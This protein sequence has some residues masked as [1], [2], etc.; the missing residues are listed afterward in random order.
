MLCVAVNLLDFLPG[1]VVSVTFPAVS[2]CKSKTKLKT[3][4]ALIERKYTSG[5]I[6]T[7]SAYANQA[8]WNIINRV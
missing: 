4:C 7:L 8:Q 1:L 6:N 2:P 3:R 5:S